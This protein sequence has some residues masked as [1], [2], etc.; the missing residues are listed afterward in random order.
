[1][2]I[3]RRFGFVAATVVASVSLAAATGAGAVAHSPLGQAAASCSVGSGEGYGYTY[4]TTLTVTRTSCSTGK[5]L[6]RHKGRVR[7][8]HCGRKVL[9]RSSVQYDARETCSKGRSRVVYNYT[10]NT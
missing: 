9:D 4:L 6:V 7:G 1:M 2:S 8:W 5:T 10:E 3:H